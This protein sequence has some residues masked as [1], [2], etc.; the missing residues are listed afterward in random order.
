MVNIVPNPGITYLAKKSTQKWFL[1]IFLPMV[2]LIAFKIS[3]HF[4]SQ[5]VSR[6]INSSALPIIVVS[7]ICI[8]PRA[9]V[10]GLLMAKS[11]LKSTPCQCHILFPNVFNPNYRQLEEAFTFL[12]L[13]VETTLACINSAA[14]FPILYFYGT[15]FRFIF[16]NMLLGR[17]KKYWGVIQTIHRISW[18]EE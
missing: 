8:L 6:K 3:L 16:K 13:Q 15:R 18:W 17:K 7:V 1:N 5:A 2:V 12:L 11:Y 4:K 9:F 10:F 14:N